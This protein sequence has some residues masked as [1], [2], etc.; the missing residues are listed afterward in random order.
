MGETNVT[1]KRMHQGGMTLLALPGGIPLPKAPLIETQKITDK[2]RAAQRCELP[3]TAL[4]Q[5]RNGYSGEGGEGIRS[6]WDVSV[7][8]YR[9]LK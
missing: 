3:K 6:S 8:V 5:I 2:K 4:I 7:C 1:P 9:N